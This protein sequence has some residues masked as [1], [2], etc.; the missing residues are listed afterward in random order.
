MYPAAI[1][2]NMTEICKLS[3]QFLKNEYPDVKVHEECPLC[4]AKGN[5][6]L[7]GDHRDESVQKSG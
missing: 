7:I 6:F 3:I 5:R 4:A 1:T 2:T